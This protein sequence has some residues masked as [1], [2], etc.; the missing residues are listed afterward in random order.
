MEEIIK[1]LRNEGNTVEA[2]EFLI[3]IYGACLLCAYTAEASS[4]LPVSEV[5][6]MVQK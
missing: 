4:N 3:L 1:D 5:S 6:F 2:V